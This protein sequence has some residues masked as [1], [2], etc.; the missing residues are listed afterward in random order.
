MLESSAQKEPLRNTSFQKSKW[1]EKTPI[2]KHPEM[3]LTEL[4]RKSNEVILIKL[5]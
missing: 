2:W 3:Y 5:P 4:L 1:R